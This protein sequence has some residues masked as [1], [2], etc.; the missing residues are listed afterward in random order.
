MKKSI[1]LCIVFMLLSIELAAQNTFEIH[2]L[3]Q[4]KNYTQGEYMGRSLYIT[5]LHNEYL[6]EKRSEANPKIPEACSPPYEACA[7]AYIFKE[8]KILKRLFSLHDLQ[9][10]VS[11]DTPQKAIEF[12]RFR[13]SEQTFFLFRPVI[14]FELFKRE[15]EERGQTF[16][17]GECSPSFFEQH[18]LKELE[19]I[20][21]E[22]SFEIHRDI[23]EVL[24]RG[25]P[26][27]PSPPMV[28]R[29]VETV[30]YTGEYTVEKKTILLHTV[31]FS[32]IPYLDGPS[33]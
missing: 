18:G 5:S 20:E 33:L 32:D 25:D 4:G 13:T 16:T 12:V 8:E 11:I 2:D 7:R 30:S 22:G 29:V 6:L 26:N 15:Q 14:W 28:Y 23:L 21:H 10:A 1:I 3:F 31:R 24:W 19:F 9:G 27:F 17:Y